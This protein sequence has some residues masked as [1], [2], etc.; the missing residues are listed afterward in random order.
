[1]RLEGVTFIYSSAVLQA[2]L[3]TGVNNVGGGREK[4]KTR[5]WEE[6]SGEIQS[7]LG[8]SRLP[9]PSAIL[10]TA[11]AYRAAPQVLPSQCGPCLLP[12]AART[13]QHPPAALAC[14]SCLITNIQTPVHL[15]FQLRCQEEKCDFLI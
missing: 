9:R 7:S 5:G 3:H 6:A 12:A 14:P 13:L 1:M 8:N 4:G 2:A 10:Q 15:Q 11:Y